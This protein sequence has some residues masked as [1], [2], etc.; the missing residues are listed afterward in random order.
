MFIVLMKYDVFVLVAICGIFPIVRLTTTVPQRF[1]SYK[2][3]SEQQ[4]KINQQKKFSTVTVI[5]TRLHCLDL[6]FTFILTLFEYRN[7]LFCLWL[8]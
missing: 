5:S 4:Q 7:N 6:Y 3:V 2:T 8:Y 1:N